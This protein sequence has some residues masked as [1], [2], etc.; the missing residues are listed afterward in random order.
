VWKSVINIKSTQ[1]K[2]Q[3]KNATITRADKCNTL[4]ILPIQQ[5]DSKMHNFIQA[6]NFQITPTDPTKSYQ[7]SVRITINISKTLTPHDTKWKYINM[8][9]SAPTIKGLIKLHKPIYSCVYDWFSHSF[10][11]LWFNT[12]W[13]CRTS[14]LLNFKIKNYSNVPPCNQEKL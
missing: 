1:S 14:K 12:Q 11:T 9:P 3:S 2:L 6:N 8:N 5:H 7:T 4:V 13:G 10:S